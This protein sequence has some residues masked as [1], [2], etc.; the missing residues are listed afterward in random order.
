MP[1]S[2]FKYFNIQGQPY[3]LDITG[4]SGC[5]VEIKDRQVYLPETQFITDGLDNYKNNTSYCV[6][7]S[8]LPEPVMNKDYIVTIDGVEHYLI[9]IQSDDASTILLIE[10]GG[11][12][13]VEMSYTGDFP[14]KPY[15]V[16][17][18]RVPNNGVSVSVQI[19]TAKVTQGPNSKLH[20]VCS[21]TGILQYE[22]TSGDTEYYKCEFH[23]SLLPLPGEF[24]E[25]VISGKHFYLHCNNCAPGLAIIRSL[26]PSI[27]GGT[28]LFNEHN[29]LE[30]EIGVYT[31]KL[32]DLADQ[33]ITFYYYPLKT[34]YMYRNDG[35]GIYFDFAVPY[36]VFMSFYPKGMLGT[37]Y[38]GGEYIRC[39]YLTGNP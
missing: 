18:Y 38:L 15:E 14:K 10:L 25:C 32:T 22:H 36:D 34:P 37:G 9:P 1:V 33:V 3:Q 35:Y 6:F 2:S 17:V 23:G 11:T 24:C 5:P 21:G 7:L 19:E 29:Q 16:Y 12:V 28:F 8:D 39:H 4:L 13:S 27:I 31:D 26:D 30:F 20:K